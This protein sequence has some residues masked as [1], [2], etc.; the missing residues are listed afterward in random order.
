MFDTKNDI[1]VLKIIK[2]INDTK[3]NTICV[4]LIKNDTK[5]DT[6]NCNACNRNLNSV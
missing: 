4:Y 1:T 5:I 6:M 2:G 3:F